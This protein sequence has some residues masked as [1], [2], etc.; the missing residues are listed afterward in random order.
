M[1]QDS[2]DSKDQI[3]FGFAAGCEAVASPA[4]NASLQFG[5]HP[6]GAFGQVTG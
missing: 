3:R 1:L 6:C 4:V 5:L 2:L